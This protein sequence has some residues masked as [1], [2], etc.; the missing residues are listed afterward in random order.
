MYYVHA[1]WLRIQD[2]AQ[3]TTYHEVNRDF[4]TH[5]DMDLAFNAVSEHFPWVIGWRLMALNVFSSKP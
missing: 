4:L 3:F 2:S 1:S 5:D